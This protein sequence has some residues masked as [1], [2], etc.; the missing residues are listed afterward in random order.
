MHSLILCS[1]YPRNS[2]PRNIRQYPQGLMSHCLTSF[3]FSRA[4]QHETL[5]RHSQ[6][7]KILLSS[8][9]QILPSVCLC[10]RWMWLFFHLPPEM[11]EN[12]AGTLSQ[13]ARHS[14][15]QRTKSPSVGASSP[16]SHTR[17]GRA[18]HCDTC[19]TEWATSLCFSQHTWPALQSHSGYCE[20]FLSAFYTV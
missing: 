3:K 11:S 19:P 17:A 8:P 9:E 16:C 18:G 14:N 2:Q 1:V 4:R 15:T 12:P 6:P 10:Y 20:R 13:R 5:S 7:I